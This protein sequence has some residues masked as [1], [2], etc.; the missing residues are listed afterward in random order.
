M[1]NRIKVLSVIDGLGYAGDESRLLSLGRTLDRDR[2]DHSVLTVNPTAYTRANEFASRREQYL[3]AGISMNDLS[4]V[5]PEE[6]YFLKAL[7]KKLYAKTGIFRRALRLARVVRKW[8]V[9]VLDCHLESAGL[10]G[11]LAGR[12]TGTPAS[13][14]LYC[15]ARVGNTMVWAWPTR[16]ALRLASAVLTD[17]RIRAAEM[18]ALIPRR[19]HKVSVIPNGIPQP[20]SSRSST[21]MRRLLGLPEDPQIRVIGMVGRLIEYKGH[22]VLLRAARTVLQREP[23]TAFLAVGY[24]RTESYKRS[25]LRQAQELGIAERFIITEYPGEIA[26]VWNAIDIH[27]HASLF[28]SLP[29][30]IAESMSLGK[31]AVVTSAGGIPEIV[32]NGYTGIIVA[33]GDPDALAAALLVVLRQ[34]ALAE[35]LGRNARSRYEQYYRPEIMARKM[36]EFF[37]NMAGKR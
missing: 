37:L 6:D 13:I 30:S 1:A 25:L 17:S 9:H 19:D 14:T 7:P 21:E 3:K 12:L 23:N 18:R 32:Q 10:V 36:E 4:E 33:P 35:R 5:S 20:Q 34:P 15:G 28:D 26:D 11:V 22:E 27:A 8:N 2:F 24:P 16:M 29:I 31:P